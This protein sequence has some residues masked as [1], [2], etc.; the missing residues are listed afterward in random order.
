M[1]HLQSSHLWTLL[2][3]IAPV[4]IPISTP[5]ST[6]PGITHICHSAIS[7][8][9]TKCLLFVKSVLGAGKV[10]LTIILVSSTLGEH[11]A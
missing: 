1:A 8:V 4:S 7:S 3:S 9:H 5:L 11:P 2:R 10:V 6:A